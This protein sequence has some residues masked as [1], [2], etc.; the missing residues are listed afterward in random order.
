MEV[1]VEDIERFSKKLKHIRKGNPILWDDI[2]TD[3]NCF[4]HALIFADTNVMLHKKDKKIIQMR[5]SIVDSMNSE[6]IAGYNKDIFRNGRVTSDGLTWPYADTD[7]IMASSKY[8]GKII[9][10]LNIGVNGG[11]T[12][13]RPNIPLH[14]NNIIFLICD[15]SI[16]YV[17]F[18][19]YKRITI[20]N[21]LKE[22]LKRIEKKK[23]KE[24]IA[25]DENGVITTS[26][27]LSEIEPNNTK[28]IY[29]N[30]YKTNKTNKRNKR[31]SISLAKEKRKKQKE[32]IE[33]QIID[34]SYLAKQMDIQYQINDNSAYARQ[35]HSQ[36][37]RSLNNREI[38]R[39]LQSEY[40]KE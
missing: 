35:L 30:K 16:H 40:N 9:V 29:K 13:M 2:T 26:F 19:S 3:G 21:K 6:K 36:M 31:N 7:V 5:Q 11:V 12:M 34:N 15:N 25:E 18:N 24:G 32:Q 33:K 23:L 14:N 28:K 1:F 39:A 37:V 20:D 4:F 27:L 10:V 22:A 8:I 38:A 17:V